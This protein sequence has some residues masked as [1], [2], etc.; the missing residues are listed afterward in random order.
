MV[1][2]SGLQ[3]FPR[4]CK[5]SKGILRVHPFRPCPFEGLRDAIGFGDT[6]QAFFG[7]VEMLHGDSMLVLRDDR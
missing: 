5:Q 2:V 7:L 1:S 3:I 4:R 6:A